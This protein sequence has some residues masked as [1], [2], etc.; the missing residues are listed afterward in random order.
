MD[1]VNF[2]LLLN[3]LGLTNRMKFAACKL[4]MAACEMLLA[5]NQGHSHSTLPT[6]PD[7]WHLTIT[8]SD[9]L[10]TGSPGPTFHL[11]EDLFWVQGLHLAKLL[12]P[13]QADG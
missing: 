10:Q 11:Y 5:S 13:Q 1:V 7:I 12:A 6:L 2:L 9:S 4:C 8:G 3:K